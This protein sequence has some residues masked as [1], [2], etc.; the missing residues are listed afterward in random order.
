MKKNRWYDKHEGLANHLEA[1]K[2]MPKRQLN[3]LLRD[4]IAFARLLH[5]TLFE[6]HLFEY[7]LDPKRRRWYDD[8][9]YLW[10]VVNGLR[11]TDDEVI[12]KVV[13]FFDKQISG[14]N[15]AAKATETVKKAATK[16]PA[17]KKKTVKKSA[18]KPVAKKKTVK[19]AA[20]KSVPAKPSKAKTVKTAPKA[21]PKA[22]TAVKK[23]AKKA[24]SRKK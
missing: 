11:F 13:A 15:K 12:H 24:A 8:D 19:P 9:P 18:A 22:K 10:L 4:L 6:D 2:T 17:A 14:K 7:P 3:E 23:V 16:A 21:R 20:K 1:L 5:P